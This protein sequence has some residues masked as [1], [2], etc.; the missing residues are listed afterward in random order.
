MISKREIEYV[1]LW[2]NKTPY[3]GIGYCSYALKELSEC[4]DLFKSDYLNKSYHILFSNNEET[5]LEVLER[6][7]CHMLGIDYKNL[8]DE[9]FDCYRKNILKMNPNELF[10]SYDLINIIAENKNE[11]LEDIERTKKCKAINFYKVAVKCAIFKKLANL[12]SFN[13]GCINFNKD[14]YERLYPD[15]PFSS[16]SK[17]LLYTQSNEMISPHFM[18]GLKQKDFED[19]YIVE[20]LFAPTD[21][22]R[23]FNLQ[24][25]VIPT[26]ITIDD[27]GALFKGNIT[28]S[29]KLQL[30]RE[31][32]SIIME[33]GFKNCI[34][35]YNDYISL[36]M[37]KQEQERK[38]T[39]K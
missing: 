14:I 10:S 17:K 30:L 16:N 15:I 12:S 1:N 29:E 39:L 21:E 20:T 13:Y 19:S 28:A 5:N 2:A 25:V 27:N 37:S 33:N 36:L 31:Y 4:L 6:N 26:Q 32:Q 24:E 34:N 18:I 38:L 23:F 7:I 8:S 22:E 35:I 11:I 3:P 9:Y